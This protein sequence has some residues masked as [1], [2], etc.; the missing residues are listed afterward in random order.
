MCAY[1]L[2]DWPVTLECKCEVINC[3][4]NLELLNERRAESL[5]ATLVVQI[6]SILW[7]FLVVVN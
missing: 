7:K 2:V 5:R 4:L 3:V 6:D 1:L